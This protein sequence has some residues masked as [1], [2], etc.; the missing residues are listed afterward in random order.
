MDELK[1]FG[2]VV[3]APAFLPGAEVAACATFR[4]VVRLSWG[5][6]RIKA[7]TMRT[8][9]ERIGCYP[10]HVSDYLAADDKPSRRNLSPEKL[11]A[12]AATVGNWGV[13]Q[14]IAK[15]SHLTIMEEVIAQRAA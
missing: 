5:H 7:M 8:L 6:R 4:E 11:N 15:Q 9:A 13:Q 3:N 14:W 10:A 1:L 12:W 2:G